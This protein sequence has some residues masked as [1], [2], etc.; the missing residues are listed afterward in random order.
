MLVTGA[1]TGTEGTRAGAGAEVG[2]RILEA[3]EKCTEVGGWSNVAV[4]LA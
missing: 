3:S 1:R 4:P 2:G